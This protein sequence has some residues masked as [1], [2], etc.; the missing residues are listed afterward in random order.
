MTN[1]TQITIVLG[2]E[3]DQ[4]LREDLLEVLRNLGAT[5]GSG[6]WAM[7]GSQELEKIS[8]EIR[9]AL[10]DVEAE[11]YIGL[12]IKGPEGVVNEIKKMI[13]MKQKRQSGTGS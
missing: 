11:T 6:E 4:D 2:D 12:A 10:V 1:E 8:F 5:S 9:G 13:E 7:A 3:F